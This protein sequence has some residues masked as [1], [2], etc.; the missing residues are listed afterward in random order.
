MLSTEECHEIERLKVLADLRIMHTP[1]SPAFDAIV[2]AAAGIFDCPIGLIS[3]V[4]QDNQWFKAKCGIALEGT[5]RSVAFCDHTIRSRSELIVTDARKDPR[6]ADNPFVLGEPHIRFYAGV[7]LSVDGRYY[8]GSLS[9]I[10][11]EPRMVTSVELTQLRRLAHAVE[12]LLLA[13]RANVRTSEALAEAEKQRQQAEAREKLLAHVESM[14]AIGAWRVDLAAGTVAWSDEVRRIHEV[15]DQVIPLE[16]GFNFYAPHDRDRVRNI[17]SRAIEG[18]ARFHFDADLITATGRE[19][20]VRVSGDIERPDGVPTHMIGIFQDITDAY[21]AEQRLWRSANIDALCDMPNR[22]W[23]QTMLAERL[24]SQTPSDATLTL[25]LLDLN[26][27]KEINDT[28]SHLA[29]DAVL[30]TVARRLQALAGDMAA[31]ARLGGDEFALLFDARL[32]HDE[33]RRLSEEILQDLRKP[34][35]FDRRSIYFSASIGIAHYPQ[36]AAT[37]DDFMRAADMA[38]YKV[39]RGGRGSV[40]RFSPEIAA[41]FDTRRVAIEK[42]RRAGAEGGIV[43]FYQPKVRLPDRSV[44]GFEALARIRNADGTISSPADFWPAFADA[45][46]S[47]LITQHIVGGVIKDMARWLGEGLDPGVVSFNVGEYSFHTPDFAAKLIRALEEK[48]IPRSLIEI[49]VTETVFWGDDPR[50]VGRTLEQLHGEGIRI[51]LDDF[52]TGYA[53]L[54]HLKD[55]P[56]DCLKIDQTFI[57]GLGARPQDMTIVNAI[58]DLGHNLGMDV[59]AEGIETEAQCEFL[60]LA[61][62]NG[63]QGYLFGK[64]MPAAEAVN[65]LGRATIARRA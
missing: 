22:I 3:L 49:E 63:G 48:Q 38:L 46:S 32:G 41:I 36:D 12:G 65:L 43:P 18:D 10:G 9:V 57:T 25:M 50:L 47:R 11:T 62:C 45:T 26:G 17:V 31:I 29:G 24:A 34:V 7:P 59:V 16:R 15:E 33:L 58:V 21:H 6:F 19:R 52:G 35:Q 20:R 54:T 4:A 56:I 64:A 37:P 30:R 60:R 55:F 14:A 61:R 40:G 5:D 28:L 51:S 23:F 1:V 39:K 53:S 44:Y 13:H 42:V 27:F 8:V 2:E